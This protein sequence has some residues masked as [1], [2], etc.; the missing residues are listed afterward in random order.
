MRLK[1]KYPVNNI[2]DVK[3][4]IIDTLDKYLLSNIKFEY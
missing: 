4:I 3:N 2:G 1:D